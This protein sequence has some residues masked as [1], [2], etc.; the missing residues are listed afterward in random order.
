MVHAMRTLRGLLTVSSCVGAFAAAAAAQTPVEKANKA[1]QAA[2]ALLAKGAYSKAVEAYADIAKKWPTTEAG[3]RAQFRTQQNTCLGRVPLQVTGRRENRIDVVIMGDGY[4][5][6]HLNEFA[7]VGKSVP[8]NMGNDPV[9]DEYAG[10]HNFWLA[11]VRSKEDGI[12]GFGRTY[13]TALNGAMLQ[14]RDEQAT[15]DHGAVK[16]M[17][18]SIDETD[19]LAVVFVRAGHLGTGGGGVAVIGGREDNTVIH[20][21]G[22]AFAGLGDEYVDKVH[23]GTTGM[24]ANVS[25]TDDPKKVPWRHWLEIKA[26]MIGIYEGAAGMQRGAWKPTAS[27][28]VME[29]GRYYCPVCREALVLEMYRRVDPI[30]GCKPPAG[31]PLVAGPDGATVEFSLL[32]PKTHGL[33][34]KVWVLP[35]GTEPPATAETPGDRGKRGPLPK[36]DA[37]AAQTTPNARATERVVLVTR[38]LKPGGYVVVARVTDDAKVPRDTLPWVIKDDRGVLQS[39]RRWN[40]VVPN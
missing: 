33:E 1:L 10:Y 12:D 16:N 30:D 17:L 23:R 38:G 19:G 15:V 25:N 29:S 21:W 37:I 7:D 9:L 24:C 18:T 11:P 22:H 6:D 39:E 36:I 31:T 27:G 3:V 28:C 4:T 13:D 8:K 34:L 26:P 35:A 5:L 40:L 2:E 14:G 20:E 32:K